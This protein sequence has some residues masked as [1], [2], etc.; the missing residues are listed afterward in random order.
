MGRG[1]KREKERDVEV[2]LCINILLKYLSGKVYLL[3]RSGR[4]VSL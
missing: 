4:Y 3:L 2:L 1:G